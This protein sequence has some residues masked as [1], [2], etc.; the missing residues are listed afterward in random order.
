MRNQVLANDVANANT[1]GFRA[2]D[3]TFSQTL[4]GALQANVVSAPAFQTANGN[5]VDLG[6][7]LAALEQ[8]TLQMQ[9]TDT[10]FSGRVAAEQQVISDMQG[11]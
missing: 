11:A 6:A 10:S 1:G 9:T 3:V 8:N 2:Q 5:G 7:V 4:N